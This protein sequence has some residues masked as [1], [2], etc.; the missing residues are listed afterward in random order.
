MAK[1]GGCEALH[2]GPERE[3]GPNRELGAFE[4]ALG[5]GEAG[6]PQPA[7][8]VLHLGGRARAQPGVQLDRL[9][10]GGGGHLPLC[11]LGQRLWPGGQSIRRWR[12][13]LSI[14]RSKRS[15]GILIGEDGGGRGAVHEHAGG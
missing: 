13:A 12:P 4:L 6:Q 10:E 3:H 8:A 5:G 1:G 14:R 15:K 2:L 11:P 7:V 9:Q